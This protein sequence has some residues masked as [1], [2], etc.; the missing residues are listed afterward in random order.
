MGDLSG[1]QILKNIA[2]KAMKLEG[3]NGTAFYDFDGIK[4]HGAFKKSYRE[5]LDTLPVDEST[6]N[7]IVD[8]ANHAFHLN[9]K[10]FDEL[11]GNWLV[12]L[13]RLTWNSL[14]SRLQPRASTPAAQST[15]S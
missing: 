5:A 14:M 9:M 13:W 2:K 1:G 4:N 7:R 11:K 8:E 3:S 6:A 10:M 12:A 15:A